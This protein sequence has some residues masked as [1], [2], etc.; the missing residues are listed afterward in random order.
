MKQLA[1]SFVETS[2]SPE[3]VWAVLADPQLRAQW[4]PNL[5]WATLDG[6]L[7]PGSTGKWKPARAQPVAVTVAEVDAPRRLV[8]EGTHGSS[9]AAR[10]HYVHEVEPLASGGARL[11]HTM[12]L[13]GP[14]APVIARFFA[15]PL[16]VSASQQAVDA[17]ARL[18]EAGTP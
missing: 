3:A 12:S 14:L 9:K 4:H 11:T 13:T 8:Y 1:R 10:G 18:A 5:R 2:A 17:V 6:P 15:R 16:G 7:A